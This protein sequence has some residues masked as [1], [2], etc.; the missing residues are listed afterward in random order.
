MCASAERQDSIE[1][2]SI[3]KSARDADSTL[4]LGDSDSALAQGRAAGKTA[5]DIPT[6][7]TVTLLTQQKAVA[8]ALDHITDNVVTAARSDELA[9][10]MN[11]GTMTDPEQAFTQGA[12]RNH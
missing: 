12:L 5:S 2:D 3:L 1:A 11:S 8:G 7:K 6:D 10:I 4:S 9:N